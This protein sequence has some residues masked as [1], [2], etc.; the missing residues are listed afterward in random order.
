MKLELRINLIERVPEHVLLLLS[1]NYSLVYQLFYKTSI[2][3]L[4]CRQR[5]QAA[6]KAVPAYENY[7]PFLVCARIYFAL[8]T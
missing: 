5:L 1:T 8:S 2:S 3:F 4:H 6:E 7:A